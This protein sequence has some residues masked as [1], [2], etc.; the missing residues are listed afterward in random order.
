M[1]P[2]TNCV[3][4]QDST[5][6]RRECTIGAMTIAT[7]PIPIVPKICALVRSLPS[8]STDANKTKTHYMNSFLYKQ[9]KTDYCMCHSVCEQK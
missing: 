3:D 9:Y 8:E 4:Q 6:T 5:K 7:Q 2:G 1:R